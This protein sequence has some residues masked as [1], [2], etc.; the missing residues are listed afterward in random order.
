M[1]PNQGGSLIIKYSYYDWLLVPKTFYLSLLIPF[2]IMIFVKGG[3][4]G[5]GGE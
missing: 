2:T 4:G 3:G 5:G 1:F